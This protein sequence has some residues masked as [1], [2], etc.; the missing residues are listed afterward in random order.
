M[1]GFSNRSPA[2]T[3]ESNAAWEDT[4]R[5]VHMDLGAHIAR[6]EL[7]NIKTYGEE[8]GVLLNRIQNADS[9]S[10][11]QDCLVEVVKHFSQK[12]QP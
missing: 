8:V 7:E 2:P 4:L 5:R 1:F 12:G 9:L 10:K 11:M 3:S 6:R